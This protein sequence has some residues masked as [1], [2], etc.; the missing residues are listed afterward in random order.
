MTMSTNI[1][2]K[3]LR[4]H[5]TLK[6]LVGYNKGEKRAGRWDDVPAHV[7]A[8]S[9]SALQAEQPEEAPPVWAENPAAVAF[10]G[11]SAVYTADVPIAG[12]GSNL[13]TDAET[14]S[15]LRALV[16]REVAKR[17][18][19]GQAPDMKI[20]GAEPLR[21]LSALVGVADGAI[22]P[23]VTVSRSN[24]PVVSFTYGGSSPAED[25]AILAETSEAQAVT[26]KA[27]DGTNVPVL[28]P[29]GDTMRVALAWNKVQRALSCW[30]A[31]DRG[32]VDL[33]TMS[34]ATK[35]VLSRKG[36][37]VWVER[38]IDLA[39]L[40]RG[41]AVLGMQESGKAPAVGVTAAVV[42]IP[43]TKKSD[44]ESD[45]YEAAVSRRLLVST[46]K[47]ARAATIILGGK[48]T[49][50]MEDQRAFETGEYARQ[51]M[52]SRGE[53]DLVKGTT[54]NAEDNFGAL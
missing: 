51:K 38:V 45:G 10:C 22:C 16:R 33:T 2:Q 14:A 7:Q 41:L 40:A 19:A 13:H 9:L 15:E 25:A 44:I 27:E 1:D 32:Q 5:Y 21:I 17:T 47:A 28:R 53:H 6:T 3:N 35:L 36:D 11:K 50:T 20:N 24:A 30:Y 8:A 26:V 23:E 29:T 46:T 39:T 49:E 52:Q 48:T 12:P 4:T 54:E 37:K 43:V 18:A 42:R 31:D 34:K